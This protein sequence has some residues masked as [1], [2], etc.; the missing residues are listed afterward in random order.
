MEEITC[1]IILR[2]GSSLKRGA[3]GKSSERN[4]YQDDTKTYTQN[5]ALFK[6]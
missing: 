5:L 2:S 6:Y 3:G 1:G 4:L